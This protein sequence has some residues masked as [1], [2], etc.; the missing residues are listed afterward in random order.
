[1]RRR[2]AEI[3]ARPCYVRLGHPPSGGMSRNFYDDT[4]EGGMSVFPAFET[5]AGEYVIEPGEDIGLINILQLLLMQGRPAFL[6]AGRVAGTGTAAEPLLADFSLEPL[7]REDLRTLWV[8]PPSSVAGVRRTLWK[9]GTQ[10]APM[11]AAWVG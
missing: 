8:Y 1:M 6:A 5:P 2:L 10:P 9:P 11:P 3:G 4:D 7:E